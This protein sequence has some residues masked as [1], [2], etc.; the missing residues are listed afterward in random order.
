MNIS[1]T[2]L[3][4]AFSLTAMSFRIGS[5]RPMPMKAMTQAKA[6]AHTARGWEKN[7]PDSTGASCVWWACVVTEILSRGLGTPHIT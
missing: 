1:E 3:G 2:W 7:E 6:T 4:V 5:T